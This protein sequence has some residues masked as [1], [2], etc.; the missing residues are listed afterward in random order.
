MLDRNISKFIDSYI[1]DFFLTIFSG[2]GAG[3]LRMV[4]AH[5]TS[6]LCEAPRQKIYCNFVR[7]ISGA[8]LHIP[9]KKKIKH[10][11]SR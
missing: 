10:R 11:K 1:P 4:Q 3:F 5:S 8:P 7:R 9:I 6:F 2:S